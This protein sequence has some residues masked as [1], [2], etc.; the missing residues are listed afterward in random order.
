MGER[1]SDVVP[2]AQEVGLQ[3]L[4][5][6]LSVIKVLADVE[7]PMILS[8]IAERAGLHRAAARR[9]LHTLIGIGYV[10]A[11]GR[12]FSL[13]PTV[14]ALGAAYLDSLRLPASAQG[15]MAELSASTGLSCSLGVLDGSDVVYVARSTGSRVLE[16]VIHVGT[17]LPAHATS[18][19][20]VLLASL[21]DEEVRER[22]AEGIEDALTPHTITSLPEFTAE[23]A[24]V[25]R[26]GWCVLDQEF[27]IGLTTL[28][29][30]VRGAGGQVIAALNLPM[31]SVTLAAGQTPTG[32]LDALLAAAKAISL[33]DV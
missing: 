31:A 4:E 23:L 24:R 28:A 30:P 3:S 2:G 33:D 16:A 26:Q 11:D 8:E 9:I 17:R 6:G 14:L 13:R 18:M 12:E 20:R 10:R 1:V 7:R 27:E 29:A 25:R 32:H 19:G 5:R 22:Y 15:V 21:S